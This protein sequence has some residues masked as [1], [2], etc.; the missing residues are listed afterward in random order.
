MSEMT[1]TQPTV[2]PDGEEDPTKAVDTTTM[3]RDEMIAWNLK[4]VEAHSHNENPYGVD[5]AIALN[6]PNI[7]QEG[8]FRARFTPTRSIFKQICR[9][10]FETI[11]F[12]R[13]R[14]PRRSAM[15][16]FVF[17]DRSADMTVVGD[18]M[19]RGPKESEALNR[20][21]PPPL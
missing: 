20:S 19:F 16:R 1:T 9:E 5:K 2:T 10:I 12:D 13:T 11:R 4:M 17:D 21:S 14:A 15:K 7:I 18:K 6:E 8:R 3:T